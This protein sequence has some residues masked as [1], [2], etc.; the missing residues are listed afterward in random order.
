[1][2]RRA[3][4]TRKRY[5]VAPICVERRRPLGL[6]PDEILREGCEQYWTAY[7]RA[8]PSKE[9]PLAGR[10]WLEIIRRFSYLDIAPRL[11]LPK[12]TMVAEDVRRERR[13]EWLE[14]FWLFNLLE[15]RRVQDE[16][17]ELI[18]IVGPP[19]DS[20]HLADA[21]LTDLIRNRDMQATEA[22]KIVG[23][24]K[25]RAGRP[26]NKR[27]LALRALELKTL[28]PGLSWTKIASRLGYV[29]DHQQR[30]VSETLPAEVRHIKRVL[31]RYG[32]WDDRR[33]P[34]Q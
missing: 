29:T 23:K 31:R 17:R 3:S 21:M 12:F 2:A 25:R 14:E 34:S 15:Y 7:D 1:M 10:I 5:P 33:R 32:L 18:N 20:A 22:G 24:W 13:R 8:F 30:P 19:P 16:I 28:E 9:H 11:S 4:T 6:P 27:W 26:A